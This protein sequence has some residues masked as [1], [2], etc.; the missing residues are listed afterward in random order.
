MGEVE[1]EL[2]EGRDEGV[3]GC[4]DERAREDVCM[5]RLSRPRGVIDR[6]RHWLCRS[7]PF[8]LFDGGGGGVDGPDFFLIF[9]PPHGQHT[10]C[11]SRK[12]ES[13]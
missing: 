7:Q 12:P 5:L 13:S 2:L 11:S 10:A 4:A 1:R 6:D 9:P 3:M 8:V